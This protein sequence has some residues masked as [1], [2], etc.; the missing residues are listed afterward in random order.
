[1]IV[2]WVKKSNFRGGAFDARLALWGE[3]ICL[4]I[5]IE[6]SDFSKIYKYI[7]DGQDFT[8]IPQELFQY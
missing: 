8:R 4:S 6:G 1:M 5:C 3:E 2:W 7:I